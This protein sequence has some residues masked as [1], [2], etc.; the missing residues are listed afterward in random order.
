MPEG[1]NWLTEWI[2]RPRAAGP[3]ARNPRGQPVIV[4]E[5]ITL[6]ILVVTG[7]IG[8][9]LSNY[10]W[11][12]KQFNKKTMGLWCFFFEGGFCGDFFLCVWFFILK[13]C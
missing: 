9:L 1:D 8:G 12:I 6:I 13:Y 3:S 11:I 5:G 7:G 4:H 2:S 10:I